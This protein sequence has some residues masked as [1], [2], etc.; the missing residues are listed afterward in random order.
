[1]QPRIPLLVGIAIFMLLTPAFAGFHLS[2][3]SYGLVA[4][5]TLWAYVL[6]LGGMFLVLVRTV[7]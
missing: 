1:M 5:I 7:R 4:I 2:S 6:G 3:Q